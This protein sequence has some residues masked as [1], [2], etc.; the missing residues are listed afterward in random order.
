MTAPALI[1]AGERKNG[2]RSAGAAALEKPGLEGGGVDL[3]MKATLRLY[4]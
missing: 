4:G 2:G 1:P 3:G